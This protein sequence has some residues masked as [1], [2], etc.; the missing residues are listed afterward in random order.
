LNPGP[1]G[2]P[3]PFQV[4]KTQAHCSACGGLEFVRSR[5]MRLERADALVCSAC[6]AE[7]LR[8]ALMQQITQKVIAQAERALERAGAVSSRAQ[9]P[10]AQPP[11][12][13]PMLKEAEELL[14]F[15]AVEGHV[16]RATKILTLIA[17]STRDVGVR[18][19]AMLAIGLAS[20]RGAQSTYNADVANL[21]RLL[22]QIREALGG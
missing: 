11:D 15:P 1:F 8:S 19:A 21:K 3:A 17:R 6:G 2:K 12:L 7:H 4:G 16:G 5:R 9:A 14:Q 13:L 18:K 10:G 22:A 20:A